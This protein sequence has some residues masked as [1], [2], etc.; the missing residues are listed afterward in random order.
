MS[1]RLG[2]LYAPHKT[3]G[4]A[5]A[6]NSNANP[7]KTWH[8]KRIRNQKAIGRFPMI[9]KDIPRRPVNFF[10]EFL[11]SRFPFAVD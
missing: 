2:L 1:C 3:F 9:H 8:L 6:F 10:C 7:A 5:G 4:L 11:A